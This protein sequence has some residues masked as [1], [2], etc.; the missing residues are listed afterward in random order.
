MNGNAMREIGGYIE[1]DTYHLPML[2]EGAVALN[3]GR[4]ALAYLLK[5][6]QIQKLWIPRFICDTVTDICERENV[7]FSFYEIGRDLLP[8]QHIKLGMGEW[9]YF[10]NY[11]SQFDN[12][13]ISEY[14]TEYSRV[15]V[16]QAQ[17]YFQMP[18]SG[19][20]TIYTCR[21]YFGVAD[22]AFLYTDAVLKQ[23]LSQ[24]ESFQR[25]RFLLGRYERPASE[26]YAEYAAN[27]DFFR[28]EPVKR[29]S[30]LTWNLLHGVDY[31]RIRR[32][33]QENYLLLHDKLG[34]LNGLRLSDQPGSFMYPLLLKNGAVIRKELQKKRIYIPT[35]W[36]DVFRFCCEGETEYELA[37][38]ILP[39]PIDQRYG[40]EEMN[41][42]VEEILRCM[43]I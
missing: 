4:N 3:C 1:L 42:M 28:T 19:V 11:Y 23:E 5:A 25:M 43:N 37:M 31:E 12:D 16:D 20:D 17:S 38:N 24:D 35:L 27:N 32:I 18:I 26:F 34:G 36:P 30:K 29:M 14:V 22:G 41:D 13:Q 7:P 9:F 2:H 40:Q 33:R 10:V 15:I 21:K 6:R 39:L 8:V